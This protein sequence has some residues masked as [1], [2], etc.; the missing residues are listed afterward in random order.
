LPD[1]LRNE[2]VARL[3]EEELRELALHL[4]VSH[5]GFAGRLSP[6]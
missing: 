3:E 1:D 4:I 6:R 5:H 2:A